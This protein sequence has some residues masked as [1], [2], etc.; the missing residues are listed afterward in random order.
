LLFIRLRPSVAAQLLLLRSNG[1]IGLPPRGPPL[2]IL[3]YNHKNIIQDGKQWDLGVSKLTGFMKHVR[4]PFDE[5]H[6]EQFHG[7]VTILEGASGEDLSHFKISYDKLQPRIVSAQ[8]TTDFSSRPGRVIYSKKKYCDAGYFRSQIDGLASYLPSVRGAS[9]VNETNPYDS[10][11]DDQLQ[12][13]LIN[14][15]IKP[16]RNH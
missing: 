1:A 7:I 4:E 15:S 10:L 8:I 9:P 3:R 14:R 12:E 16:K 11:P 13:M 2:R 6:V 5:G